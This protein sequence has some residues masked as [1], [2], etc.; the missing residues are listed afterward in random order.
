MAYT[1]SYGRLSQPLGVVRPEGWHCLAVGPLCVSLVGQV[2]AA[3]LERKVI[4]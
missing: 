1:G 2:H 4:S 3:T